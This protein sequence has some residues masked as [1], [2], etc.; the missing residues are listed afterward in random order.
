MLMQLV[1]GPYR[2]R[3]RDTIDVSWRLIREA[4]PE[5]ARLFGLQIA[6]ALGFTVLVLW[7]LA[8]PDA[9]LALDEV[10][11]VAACGALAPLHELTHAAAFPRSADGTRILELR[12]S[13]VLLCARY[14]GTLSRNRYVATM[15][16]PLLALSFAP[17]GVAAC[18]GF[19]PSE[20]VVISIVNA[21]VSGG[22][23]LAAILALTQVP[24][25]ATIRMER[26]RIAW[27]APSPSSA[28]TVESS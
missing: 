1:L 7:L 16:L 21:L 4:D 9:E 28:P 3:P 27:R 12:L 11:L 17:V 19:A 25:G 24:A 14:T 15:V 18:A 5:L 6:L 13:R 22:D 8:I 23:V 20:V 26:D 2:E 10:T